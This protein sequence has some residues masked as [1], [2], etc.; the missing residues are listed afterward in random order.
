MYALVVYTG[1]D[2]KLVLNEGE[3]DFKISNL[4][5][6]LNIYLAINI[7]TMLSLMLIFSH[8][9]NRIW[10]ENNAEKHFYIFSQDELPIDKE[11]IVAKS[12]MSFFLLFNA[13]LPLDL[14]IVLTM[15]KGLYT[16]FMIWDY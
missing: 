16:L 12:M 2:T 9:G 4:V 7:A 1:K 14:P 5:K 10:L 15:S 11:G 3:Y 6:R 13:I 8:V